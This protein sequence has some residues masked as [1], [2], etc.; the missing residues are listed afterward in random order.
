V[1]LTRAGASDTAARLFGAAPE[2]VR[3]LIGAAWPL[4]VGPELSRRT[5]VLGIERGTLRIRVPDAR[6]RKVLHAM[7]PDILRRLR[8]I[9]GSLAPFRIGFVEG[10]M[11]D[12]DP[13]P[14]PAAPGPPADLSTAIAGPAAAIADPEIRRRFLATAARYLDRHR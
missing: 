13:S 6:W 4:A 10:G 7:Q 8:E 2:R 5:E 14:P 3:A 12:S 11:K 1:A 9:A